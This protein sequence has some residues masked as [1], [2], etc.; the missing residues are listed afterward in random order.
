MKSILKYGITILIIV[1]VVFGIITLVDLN[2]STD[3]LYTKISGMCFS[4]Q[5]T[6]VSFDGQ[7]L[8]K[9]LESELTVNHT[10]IQQLNI[11]VDKQVYLELKEVES[12]NN[13]LFDYYYQKSALCIKAD[14]SWQDAVLNKMNAVID[15]HK[16]MVSEYNVLLNYLYSPD[17]NYD[18]LTYYFNKFVISF[19]YKQ[20]QYSNL[21]NEFGRFILDQVY[22]NNTNSLSLIGNNIIA[23]FNVLCTEKLNV[24]A[25]EDSL[26]SSSAIIAEAKHL[27]SRYSTINKTGTLDVNDYEFLNSI[28]QCT[29]LDTF[30]AN[31]NKVAFYNE[32]PAETKQA[33]QFIYNYLFQF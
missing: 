6:Y 33:Y 28:H 32:Q 19:N 25:N 2:R 10:A 7:S 15:A 12:I 20:I 27:R 29:L 5:I 18:Y 11:S 26:V 24:C 16:N 1:G 30:L 14:K 31:E 23:K 3:Y 9:E 13:L 22:N 8:Y 21:C 4:D 17:A